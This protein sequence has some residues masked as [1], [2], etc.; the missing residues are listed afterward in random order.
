MFQFYL[1]LL[2]V[3]SLSALSSQLFFYIYSFLSILP[4]FS[5][6]IVYEIIIYQPSANV[7][8]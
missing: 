4:F 1:A 7:A 5:I 8:Q 2:L 3:S 6:E